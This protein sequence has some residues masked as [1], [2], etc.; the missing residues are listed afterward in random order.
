MS[1]LDYMR[2]FV[3][4]VDSGSITAAAE[5]FDLTVA[6]VSKRLKALELELG[7][8]LLTRNTR[9]MALTEAGHYYY[10]HC[11]GILDEVARVDQH[12]Q[13]MQ[14]KL[15]GSIRINMP[16]TYGKLRL[17]RWLLSFLREHPDIHIVTQLDD[18]YT[19]AA[20][21]EYDIVIRIGSLNDSGLIARKLDNVYLLPV[22]SPA[23]LQQHG[24]PK[25]PMELAGHTC[26]HYT[27][28]SIRDGWGFYD[29][30]GNEFIPPIMGQASTPLCANN[31]EI[32]RDAV[33]AGF[34]IAVLPD[35][36]VVEHIE[37]G[38]LIR[39]LPDYHL[40]DFAVYAVY[41]SRQFL[42]EKTRALVEYL[43]KNLK[44]GA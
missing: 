24:E 30:A 3:E 41:P 27:N 2:N 44:G 26:L 40:Q 15:S 13:D 17:G 18:A 29:K 25:H 33:L 32:L 34:G 43:V 14:S 10:Q 28:I 8:R 36:E 16:M 4:V 42:P 21:G 23:Y 31:G 9:Q 5:R 22:S 37:R 19:D 1:R 35:F 38:E 12:L 39:L 7:T 11:R 6:A 20:R